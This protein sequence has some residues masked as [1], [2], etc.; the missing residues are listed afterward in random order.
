MAERS[1]YDIIIRYEG[2]EEIEVKNN[3]SRTEA[4]ELMRSLF[5]GM[6]YDEVTVQIQKKIPE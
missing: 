6:S 4:V 1:I 5:R 3:L 2:D